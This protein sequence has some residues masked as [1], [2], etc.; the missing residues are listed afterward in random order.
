MTNDQDSDEGNGWNPEP[1]QLRDG[2]H[3]DIDSHAA[4]NIEQI[5][6]AEKD[7]IYSKKEADEKIDRM[8]QRQDN[9]E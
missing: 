4:R 1:A 3:K 7:G 9:N 5:R 8:K 2:E 6:E